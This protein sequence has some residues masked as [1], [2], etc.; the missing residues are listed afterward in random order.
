MDSKKTGKKNS[1][2]ASK[3]IEKARQ[4]KLNNQKAINKNQQEFENPDLNS[5]LNNQQIKEQLAEQQSNKT[6][7]QSGLLLLSFSLLCWLAQIFFTSGYAPTYGGLPL[8]GGI[9]G[10]FTVDEAKSSYQINVSQY[11]LQVGAWN[12]VDIEVLDANK[13]YVFGFGDELWRETGYDEG[14]WDESKNDVEMRMHFEKAG[15]YYLSISAQSNMTLDDR[16]RYMITIEQQ[17]GSDV[18]LW[19]LKWAALVLG[20]FLLLYRFRDKLGESD[21]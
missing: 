4:A 14:H 11:P 12:A 10:P 5:F 17:R 7:A 2:T 16:Q 19:L 21:E 13:Q 9:Y 6:F 1:S 3:N 18:A 20:S 15:Q 8:N